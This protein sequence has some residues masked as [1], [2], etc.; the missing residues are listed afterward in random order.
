[1]NDVV[2]PGSLDLPLVDLGSD[3]ATRPTAAM[4]R[5]MVDAAVGDEQRGDDPTVCAL[6]ER[7][8]SMLGM[9]RALFL[10]S[11]T[12]ANQIALALHA[13]A[14][15]EV[16]CHRTAHVMNHEGGGVA[17]T[18]RAQLQPLDTP[19]GI[20]GAVDVEHVIRVE[21]PHH[22]R[23]TCV[24]I[25]NTSN[26][27][28]GSVWPLATLDDVMDCAREHHLAVHVDG[29]RLWHAAIA[30]EVPL[31]RLVRGATTVQ[32]C[33][34]KG[35]GCG[36]G[37]TLALSSSLWPRARRLKQALGGALRQAGFAAG[38]M[39]YALDH[40]LERL[41]ED[42]ARARTLAL[43][44]LEL[45]GINV[46][47]PETN[48]VFFRVTTTNAADFCERLLVHGVRMAPAGRDRIRAATHLDVD[49]AGIV[50]A[51]AAVRAVAASLPA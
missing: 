10:P 48:L 11:A 19:R 37:A 2:T 12:M 22:P 49:D 6:E 46:E 33:F 28:G 21:D 7:V 47:I 31:S 43:G 41:H 50:R 26:S 34:S 23:T 40:H 3:T 24:V 38:A 45:P 42:H 18:S 15:D 1:M 39:L 29:A 14:G 25:E 27:G 9:E 4:K 36:M 35:L 8:A 51:I 44:L 17:M 30:L 32:L 13:G 20:F 5:A 16:V